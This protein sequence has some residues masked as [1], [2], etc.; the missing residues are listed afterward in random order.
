MIPKLSQPLTKAIRTIEGVL[1]IVIDA[2]LAV[3]A[4]LAP[5]KLPPEVAAI[6][7]SANTGLLVAGRTLLKIFA[8]QKGVGIEPP[9]DA[10]E[11]D[12]PPESARTPDLA[13]AQAA[14]SAGEVPGA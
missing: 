5:H 10:G 13:P 11:L 12:L 6:L 2:G 14:P 8:I 3:G 7:G 1:V 4:A 9:A